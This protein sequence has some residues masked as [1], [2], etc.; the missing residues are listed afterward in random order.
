MVSIL[1]PDRAIKPTGTVWNS[2]PAAYPAVG[3]SI[4]RRTS[5]PE[6]FQQGMF[7]SAADM[8]SGTMETQLL[9]IR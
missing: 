4:D 1:R 9:G 7:V 8:I 5:P 6:Q 2:D 3:V